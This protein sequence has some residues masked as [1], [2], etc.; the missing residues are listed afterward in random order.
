MSA[1]AVLARDHR[2]AHLPQGDA[3]W[4]GAIRELHDAGYSEHQIASALSIS[5]E[6]VRALLEVHHD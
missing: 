6:A 5:I 3:T 4:R 2:S 1:L